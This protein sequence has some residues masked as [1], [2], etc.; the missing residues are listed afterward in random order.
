MTRY[1]TAVVVVAAGPLWWIASIQTPSPDVPRD[2]CTVLTRAQVQ[3]L[4]VGKR[5]VRV[6]RRRNAQNRAVECTWVSGFF[7][8]ASFR[9]AHDA[10]SLQLTV[11][12]TATAITAL[13]D[14]RAR[15]H[16][17]TNETTS[18]VPNL[19]DEAYLHLGDVIAVS[20]PLVVQVGLSN[21]DSAAKPYPPVD[22]IARQAAALALRQ[23]G[24]SPG[25]AGA[26][27]GARPPRRGDG[28]GNGNG[29]GSRPVAAASPTS[30]RPGSG[31]SN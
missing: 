17:P 25:L 16:N 5:V 31:W 8:T 22:D 12:P 6:K 14:L 9:R 2:P 11:Q 21:Y 26:A 15:A 23:L 10:L 4:L 18:T 13:N 30:E 27:A 24:R 3:R 28:N 1:V 29:R 7:Q 19:G 20:G